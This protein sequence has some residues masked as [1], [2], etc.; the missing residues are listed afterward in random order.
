MNWSIP[1]SVVGTVKHKTYSNILYCRFYKGIQLDGVGLL[2]CNQFGLSVLGR[3]KDPYQE[4]DGHDLLLQRDENN[5]FVILALLLLFEYC[6][7]LHKHKNLE[8]SSCLKGMSILVHFTA[9]A[10]GLGVCKDILSE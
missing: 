5:F 7:H 10:L 9:C 3:D 4:M 2:L 1:P 6:V 8:K